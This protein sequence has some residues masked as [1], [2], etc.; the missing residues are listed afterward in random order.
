[1][2]LGNTNKENDCNYWDIGDEFFNRVSYWTDE[3]VL[4]RALGGGTVH[5]NTEGHRIITDILFDY[6]V[7]NRLVSLS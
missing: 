1:M 3:L 2:S 7:Q 6:L 4:G 5:D